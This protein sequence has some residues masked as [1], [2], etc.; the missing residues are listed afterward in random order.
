MMMTIAVAV[1]ALA[2]AVDA[3]NQDTRGTSR[4][5]VIHNFATTAVP[6]PATV[7]VRIG[8]N[9]DPLTNPIK[10]AGAAYG[11]VTQYLRPK[12]PVIAGVYLAGTTT[13]LL[14]ANLGATRRSRLT[15][16]ARPVSATDGTFTVE[17]LDD[18]TRKKTNKT[19]NVRVIHGIPSAAA[20]DVRIGAVGVGCLTPPVSYPANAVL[21]VPAGTYTLGVFPPSDPD[22]QGEP[23]PGLRA[24]AKLRGRSAVTAIARVKPG[25]P[26]TFQLE[27]IRDF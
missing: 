11:D 23:L 15:L 13:E 17:V 24:Q 18:A 20:D 6:Q 16:L 12:P 4:V 22:C 27:L 25:A 14:S 9:A 5:R 8:R 19:A 3:K 1:T 26:N 21:D 2:G 10:V 7:D